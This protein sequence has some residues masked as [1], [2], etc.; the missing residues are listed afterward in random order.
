[1][2][3]VFYENAYPDYKTSTGESLVDW[4][5]YYRVNYYQPTGWI[6]AALY[7]FQ[8]FRPY[9]DAIYLN[10]ANF[11]EDLRSL[12]G[13]QAFFEF[14]KDYAN[15]E[16]HKVATANDFFSILKHHTAQ[17]LDDLI[18]AYFKTSH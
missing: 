9:R 18:G 16:K 11:L 2:E 10:G 3:H 13:D 15:S 5:W 8:L 12:I 1:M 7:D 14:L 6:D 17:N 4:W